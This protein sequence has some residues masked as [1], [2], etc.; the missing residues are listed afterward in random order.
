MRSAFV[1][2]ACAIASEAH[3]A[4][5]EEPVWATSDCLSYEDQVGPV[6]FSNCSS[7]FGSFFI[8]FFSFGYTFQVSFADVCSCS[9][10]F[11]C[12]SMARP[13][14]QSECWI[15]YWMDTKT[16]ACGLVTRVVTMPTGMRVPGKSRRAKKDMS[17]VL[18][19][20]EWTLSKDRQHIGSVA[21]TAF[22]R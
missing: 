19:S 14:R 17:H 4:R 11:K 12:L 5:L 22:I 3:L 15:N 20:E 18:E 2:P 16:A 13:A 9:Y 7:S 6:P 8:G 21:S 1:T 10:I